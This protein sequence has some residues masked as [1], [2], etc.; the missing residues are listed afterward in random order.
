MKRTND[1]IG[2][3]AHRRGVQSCTLWKFIFQHFRWVEDQK[4]S[5]GIVE[6][7]P[8][9]IKI[10]NHWMLLPPYN[11]TKCKSYE[12]AKGAIKDPFTVEKLKFFSFIAGR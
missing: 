1:H 10:M 12:V 9:V 4:V 5:Q 6:I 2:G 8:S 3:L 7:W 11:Q